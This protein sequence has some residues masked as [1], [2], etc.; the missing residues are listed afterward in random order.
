MATIRREIRT[1]AAPDAV[2]DAIADVGALH[3]RLVPGFVVDTRLEG[4]SRIV[5]FGNGMVIE[6]PIVTVDAAERRLVCGAKGGSLSHYNGAVQVFAEATGCRVVW[7]A[8]F[9]PHEATAVVGPM[10]EEGM[11]VMKQTLDAA[12]A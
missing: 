9:L 10:I 8:D 2:W 11:R 6:E 5:T 12:A 1:T 3:T 7:T 4:G